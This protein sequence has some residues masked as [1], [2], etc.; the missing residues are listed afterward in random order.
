MNDRGTETNTGAKRRDAVQRA[1]VSAILSRPSQDWKVRVVEGIPTTD[2]ELGAAVLKLEQWK[3]VRAARTACSV[4]PMG[5]I[6]LDAAFLVETIDTRLEEYFEPRDGSYTDNRVTAHFGDGNT[7]GGVQVTGGQ[8]NSAQ[9]SVQIGSIEQ[10]KVRDLA[11]AAL[12]TLDDDAPQAL[13]DALTEVRSEAEKAQPNRQRLTDVVLQA[14]T[15]AV[16]S[17]AAQ[18]T[19]DY[20]GQIAAAIST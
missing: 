6:P 9:Q 7:V 5:L 11:H 8:G 14:F 15:V 19:L 4:L 3:V 1:I 13:R 10:A 20:L 2:A 12:A 17:E 16:A 18:Q